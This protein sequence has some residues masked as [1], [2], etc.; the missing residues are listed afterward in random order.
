[1]G[2][3]QGYMLVTPLQLAAATAIFANKGKW[4]RP[5]LTMDGDLDEVQEQIQ[6]DLKGAEAKNII[7]DDPKNWDRMF[8]AMRDVMHG[9][10]GTARS[11]GRN[12][13][14]KMAGKTGTAQVL[15]IAQDEEYD[16]TK[17]SEW[18]RDHAW[19]MGFAPLDD[20]QIAV[21][22]LVENGGGGSSAAAP[23]ARK[24]FDAHLLGKYEVE[25]SE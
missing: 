3:G 19:F 21:A 7:L 10:R 11:S 9:A 20:P 17:I 12:A 18:H 25:A 6:S 16:E 5:K 24:L 2:L 15:G 1:M 13:Q 23:V 22:V 8:A 14:Y 4:V